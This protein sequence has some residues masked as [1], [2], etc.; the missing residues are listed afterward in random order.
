MGGPYDASMCSCCPG[1]GT[2]AGPL[3]K[4]KPTKP[5]DIKTTDLNTI[6]PLQERFQKLAKPLLEQ[7]W[8]PTGPCYCDAADSS[9]IA[10]SIYYRYEINGT[11]GNF[12]AGGPTG[13][14][15]I[16]GQTPQVGQVFDIT[17]GINTCTGNN[18]GGNTSN[19]LD[20]N[21]RIFYV[22]PCAP[23]ASTPNNNDG[24]SNTRFSIIIHFPHPRLYRFNSIKL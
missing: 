1:T 20:I 22:N 21:L 24:R 19:M 2:P 16:N 7:Q 9:E 17:T 13:H 15:T 8:P 4:K 18:W 12:M 6:E 14:M 5:I 10:R 3:P 23:I 11:S